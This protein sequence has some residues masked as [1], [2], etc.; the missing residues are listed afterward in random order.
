MKCECGCEEFYAHQVCHLDIKVDGDGNFLD[1]VHVGYVE[2]DI[3]HSDPPFGPFVCVDC[4]K[5]YSK[6][7]A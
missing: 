6:L 1:N 5:E 7:T 4:D 3:Y 2:K